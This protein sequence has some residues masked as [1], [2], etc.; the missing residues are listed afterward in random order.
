[1]AVLSI[2][3]HA[4]FRISQL[5]LFLTALQ[6]PPGELLFIGSVTSSQTSTIASPFPPQISLP[7]QWPVTIGMPR[8]STCNSKFKSE[9]EETPGRIKC[10]WHSPDHLAV[11]SPFFLA[12]SSLSYA[13]APGHCFPR[14]KFSN[15]NLFPGLTLF[16]GLSN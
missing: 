5:L 2:P 4:D 14:I 9:E 7:T 1:M 3:L 11:D 15:L 12:L 6:L 10:L 16:L 13:A 8:S